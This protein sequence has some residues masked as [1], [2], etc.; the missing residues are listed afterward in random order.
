[1]VNLRVDIVQD[2]VSAFVIHCVDQIGLGIV[3]LTQDLLQV[4]LLREIGQEQD[5]TLG[6]F[7]VGK[8]L[9]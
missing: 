9:L 8:S 7:K 2:K 1:M 3:S 4:L 5:W 6:F